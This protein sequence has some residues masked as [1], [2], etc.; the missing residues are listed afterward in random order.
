MLAI[1][2]GE[3]GLVKPGEEKELLKVALHD[4]SLNKPEEDGEDEPGS[5][6]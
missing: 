3:N 1:V 2:P 6:G 5:D 4:I